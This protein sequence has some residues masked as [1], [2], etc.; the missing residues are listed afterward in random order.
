M[1]RVE[2]LRL[3]ELRVEVVLGLVPAHR[4]AVLEA[5]LG[6]PQHDRVLR[7]QLPGERLDLAAQLRERHARVDEAHL[8]RLLAVERAPVM[9]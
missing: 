7:E 9:T 3:L 5:E 8:G 4:L 6:R 1:L 2:E